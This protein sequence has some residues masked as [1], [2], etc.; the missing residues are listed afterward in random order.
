VS[1]DITLRFCSGND[2]ASKAIM[3]FERSPW[4]H[5]EAVTFYGNMLGALLDGVKSRPADYAVYAKTK[6]VSISATWDQVA[7]FWKFLVDQIG[8]PYDKLAII[9]FAVDRDWR[10]AGHWFCSE[11]IAAAL[12]HAGVIK[13]LEPHVNRVTPRDLFLVCSAITEV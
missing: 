8:K 1:C 13:R 11:L 6:T 5:V 4:S 12:E 9:G 10:K 3:V 2:I 7:D